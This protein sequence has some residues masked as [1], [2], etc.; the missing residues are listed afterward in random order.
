MFNESIRNNYTITYDSGCTEQKLPT[1]GNELQVD[2]GSAQKVYSPK[3]LIAAF[4]TLDRVGANNKSNNI[5]IF[6]N[7]I[8]KQ[9]F[10]EIDG[11]RYPKDAVLTNFPENDFLDQN[12]DLKLVYKEYVGEE[13]MNFFIS[14][15][16]KNNY[17]IQVIDLR[18]QVDHITP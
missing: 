2:I 5:A 3:Y 7:V 15:D 12:R 1:D 4:Q 9:Y 16:M 17:P 14:F 13:L 8:V 10:C 18:H 11:Y 6:D